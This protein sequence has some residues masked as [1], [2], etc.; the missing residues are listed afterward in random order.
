MTSSINAFQKFLSTC[1]ELLSADGNNEA[2]E[3]IARADA[4]LEETG[5][6]NW[7]G[8]TKIFT[9]YLAIPP[10]YFAAHSSKKEQLEEQ[11]N[12]RLQATLPSGKTSRAPCSFSATVWRAI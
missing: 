8:G 6:D 2:V 4:R 11:I 1:T 9:I 7:N 5:Y 10:S 12:K 3:I